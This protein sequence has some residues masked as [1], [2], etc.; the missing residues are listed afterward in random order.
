MCEDKWE[1]VA[2]DVVPLS[3]TERYKR[4]FWISI[5]FV[6]PDSVE[7]ELQEFLL[8]KT[9]CEVFHSGVIQKQHALMIDVVKVF[10]GSG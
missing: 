7:E 4:K 1:I 3:A 6:D 9:R 2:P 8:F 5:C 10:P